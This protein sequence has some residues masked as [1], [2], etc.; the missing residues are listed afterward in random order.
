M[1]SQS[2]RLPMTTLTHGRA[3]APAGRGGGGVGSLDMDGHADAST[4]AAK[5]Y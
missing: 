5:S 4:V 1:V 2:E 3:A